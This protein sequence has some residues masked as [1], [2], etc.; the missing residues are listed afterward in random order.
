[1]KT[2]SKAKMRPISLN[3]EEDSTLVAIGNG[4]RTAGVKELME[5]HR[6]ISKIKVKDQQELKYKVSSLVEAFL[7]S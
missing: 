4:S 5:L 2:I 6:I 3:D 7:K 1:M